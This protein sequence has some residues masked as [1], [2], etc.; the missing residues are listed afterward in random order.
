MADLFDK[1]LVGINKG[2]TSVSEGSKN[3][4]EKAK[5][6][7]AISDA[8]KEKNKIAQQL[9]I[10]AYNLY[11]NG[12]ALPVELRNFCLEIT[13]KNETIQAL[14]KKLAELDNKEPSAGGSVCACGFVCRPG[15]HFCP[16]CGNAL[17][18]S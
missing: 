7:T 2:V 8:E 17:K 9:G 3:L 5:I 14:Q 18:N 1:M 16:K 6:N 13:D 12:T 11:L 15:A 10:Q 4:M